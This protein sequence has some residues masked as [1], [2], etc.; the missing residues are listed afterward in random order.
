LFGGSEEPR[1][2]HSDIC[3]SALGAGA[4]DERGARLPHGGGEALLLCLYGSRA[5]HYGGR[6]RPSRARQ[7]D[8][9][10]AYSLAVPVRVRDGSELLAVSQTAILRPR[11]WLGPVLDR[12]SAHTGSDLVESNTV[13][14]RPGDCTISLGTRT[15]GQRRPGRRAAVPP[16][17]NALRAKGVDPGAPPSSGLDRRWSADSH[18]RPRRAGLLTGADRGRAQRRLLGSGP[19]RRV[20]PRPSA[21][22]WRSRDESVPPRPPHG[23]NLYLSLQHRHQKFRYFQTVCFIRLSF[24]LALHHHYFRV[25]IRR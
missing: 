9:W 23:R 24:F 18:R 17:H 3:L 21:S 5:R 2:G 22:R 12:Y 4:T 19:F 11:M 8:I 13:R 25:Q 20:P 16:S 14:E 10:T 6:L 15:E 7:S 1:G